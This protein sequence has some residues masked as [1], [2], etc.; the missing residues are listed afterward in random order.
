MNLKILVP[1]TAIAA[2]G[3]TGHATAAAP[4]PVVEVQADCASGLTITTSG[5][6]EGSAGM[7]TI[8]SEPPRGLALNGTVHADWPVSIDVFDYVVMAVPG[9]GQTV[10]GTV[11]CHV[12]P[13][14]A[15]PVAPMVVASPEPILPVFEPSLLWPG[16]E[17]ADPW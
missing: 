5:Y 16:L 7:F 15:A 4:P 14:I 1:L 13:V 2:L 8:G 10:T 3:F 9:D 12:E 6:P 17:L 11:D